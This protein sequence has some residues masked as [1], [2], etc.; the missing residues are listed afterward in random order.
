M[1]HVNYFFL[2]EL[3]YSSVISYIQEKV[4]IKT[5]CEGYFSEGSFVAT[6][7]LATMTTICTVGHYL[8]S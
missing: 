6:L 8:Y 3:I 5:A 1:N 7:K 4:D 2:I